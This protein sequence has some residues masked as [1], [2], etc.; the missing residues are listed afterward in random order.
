MYVPSL[1]CSSRYAS[2]TEIRDLAEAL[3]A[4]KWVERAKG[5]L[6][7]K[8]GLTEHDAYQKNL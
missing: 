2:S 1:R 5:V 8:Y 4:R 6:R 3:E 7:Q